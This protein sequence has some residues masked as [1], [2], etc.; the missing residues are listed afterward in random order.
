MVSTE[1][2]GQ[3]DDELG[4]ISTVYMEQAARLF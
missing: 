3:K 4:E 1:R 2:L